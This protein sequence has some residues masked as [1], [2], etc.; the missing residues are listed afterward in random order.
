MLVQNHLINILGGAH[1]YIDEQ[2][3]GANHLDQNPTCKGI[4]QTAHFDPEGTRI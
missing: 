3:F 1:K 4:Y 2:F